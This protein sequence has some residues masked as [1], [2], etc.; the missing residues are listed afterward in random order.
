MPFSPLNPN[1]GTQILVLL[2]A[3]ETLIHTHIVHTHPHPHRHRQSNNR[4]TYTG[5]QK[6]R[7]WE[8]EWNR[9]NKRIRLMLCQYFDE[10]HLNT[11]LIGSPTERSKKEYRKHFAPKQK[12]PKQIHR[13]DKADE[14]CWKK[15]K[16]EWVERN[17]LHVTL[18]FWHF[19]QKVVSAVFLLLLT[20]FLLG[21][22]LIP[23]SIRCYQFKSIYI[24][25]INY[26]PFHGFWS[27]TN[28]QRESLNIR[29]NHRYPTIEAI[30]YFMVISQDVEGG[31][32]G[33]FLGVT[34][35][36]WVCYVR[37]QIVYE[38]SIHNKEVGTIFKLHNSHFPFVVRAILSSSC[39]MSM[40]FHE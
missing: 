1:A 27:T 25:C 35:R 26:Y 29:R 16:S 17:S 15:I 10:A 8:G 5:G 9:E 33:S 11:I 6:Q 28:V 12:I 19:G 34:H 13:Y 39:S 4:T 2:L 18:A 38:L 37:K 40:D 21:T 22:I 3:T 24:I 23:T 31:F 14:K 20:A 7:A 30:Y 32:I 36:W